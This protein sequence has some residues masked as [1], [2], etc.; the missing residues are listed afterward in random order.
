MVFKNKIKIYNTGLADF[1]YW[2]IYHLQKTDNV[3]VD[4]ISY[5]VLRSILIKLNNGFIVFR[6]IRKLLT[7]KSNILR[8]ESSFKDIIKGAIAP[9]TLLFNKN[10]I[11]SALAY[12]N[13]VYYTFLLTLFRKNM[14]YF[15]SWPYWN[16]NKYEEKPFFNK[17]IWHQFLKRVK[18]VTVS[19]TSCDVLKSKGYNPIQIPHSVDINTYKNNNEKNK[20][21]KILYVGRIFEG[22]GIKEIL[23]ISSKFDPSVISSS[24]SFNIRSNS[25]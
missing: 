1:Y 9:I 11:F 3:D 22:K 20:K 10:I 6:L 19:K 13:R 14:I 15:T 23:D 5:R 8:D 24:T 4:Q 12:S 17:W 2:N 16:T 25:S 18:I 7:N 21:V